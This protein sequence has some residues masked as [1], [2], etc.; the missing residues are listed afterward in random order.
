[1]LLIWWLDHIWQRVKKLNPLQS[2]P[3]SLIKRIFRLL[4]LTLSLLSGCDCVCG[5]REEMCWCYASR[6]ERDRLSVYQHER[7]RGARVLFSNSSTSPLE[8]AVHREKAGAPRACG[9]SRRHPVN[10]DRRQVVISLIYR[11]DIEHQSLFPAPLQQ[12][13]KIYDPVR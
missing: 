10:L 8:A 12:N 5:G 11:A 3:H 9:L 13:K 1:M 4:P 2:W 7:R 6:I